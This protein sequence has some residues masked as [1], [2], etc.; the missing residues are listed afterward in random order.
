MITASPQVTYSFLL[1]PSSAFP[2]SLFPLLYPCRLVICCLEQL[3]PPSSLLLSSL[4][5][6]NC[7]FF[8]FVLKLQKSRVSYAGPCL[9]ALMAG[10][11]S[12]TQLRR[13]SSVAVQQDSQENSARTVRNC[14]MTAAICMHTVC[15]IGNSLFSLWYYYGCI[16]FY[17]EARSKRVLG[18]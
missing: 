10:N 8:P 16:K 17:A 18:L 6:L 1:S 5:H 14:A 7:T 9:H 11:V 4:S 13:R 2:L 3:P 15:W 12:W